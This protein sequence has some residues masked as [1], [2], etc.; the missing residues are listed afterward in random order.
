MNTT[1]AIRK[2]SLITIATKVGGQV[3][4]TKKEAQ[5]YIKHCAAHNYD[6]KLEA[7]DLG[8]GRLWVYLS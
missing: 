1:T 6:Y 5:K 8:G 7:N 2:A 3:R 4:I